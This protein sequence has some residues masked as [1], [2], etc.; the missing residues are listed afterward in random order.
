[1]NTIETARAIKKH[2]IDLAVNDKLPLDLND[3]SVS[4]L[5]TVIKGVTSDY[6]KAMEKAGELLCD[7]DLSTE[8]QV[9]LIAKQANIDGYDMIDN[10]DGVIV[11]EKVVNSFTCDEFLEHINYVSK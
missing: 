1:M 6:D 4:A 10:V 2:L 8:E 11:W 3:L 9:E 7:G 5:V